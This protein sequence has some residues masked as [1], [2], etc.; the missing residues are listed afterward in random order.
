MKTLPRL[1]S[2]LLS[3]SINITGHII[4]LHL[5]LSPW[6]IPCSGTFQ[7][8]Y[9][10]FHIYFI[11]RLQR[12]IQTIF[13]ASGLCSES[14]T[15][16]KVS[17]Q[18]SVDS[19]AQLKMA[20][21]AKGNNVVMTDRNSTS[22]HI[23]FDLFSLFMFGRKM[24]HSLAWKVLEFVLENEHLN[25]FGRVVHLSGDSLIH[26]QHRLRTL[27]TGFSRADLQIHS[28]DPS[29]Q[30]QMLTHTHMHVF[31]VTY[32]LEYIYNYI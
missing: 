32:C 19:V 12:R 15:F 11:N 23:G 13:R 30:P 25:L 29:Q 9:Q 22:L 27:V 4:P 7:T 1:T 17:A 28:E 31:T 21:R 16:T 18:S 26:S 24:H 20:K 10:L 2:L 6:W 3:P 8:F 5:P 14:N